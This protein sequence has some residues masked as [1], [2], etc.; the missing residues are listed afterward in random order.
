MF[1]K[2][3]E[4]IQYIRQI[5]HT[6]MEDIAKAAGVSQGTVS[7]WGSGKIQT[8]KPWVGWGIAKKYNIDPLWLLTGIGSPETSENSNAE[9]VKLHYYVEEGEDPLSEIEHY[10]Y[11]DRE[12]FLTHQINPEDCVLVDAP[13]NS[14]E[15]LIFKGDILLVYIPDI[16]YNYALEMET[17]IYFIKI[18]NKYFIRKIYP[19]I[20]DLLISSENEKFGEEIIK[21]DDRNKINIIGRVIARYGTTP[22][23]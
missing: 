5:K 4:R 1:E 8:I 12:I 20:T 10:R 2:L 9:T 17:R 19:R 15:P 21:D 7:Q 11:L 23:L 22:F 18:N 14:M 16:S 13:D 6:S 3:S